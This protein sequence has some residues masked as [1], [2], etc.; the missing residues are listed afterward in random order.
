MGWM[1]DQPAPTGA[2]G[3]PHQSVDSQ[4][5]DQI[6]TAT[7]TG[8]RP[9]PFSVSRYPKRRRISAVATLLDDSCSFKPLQAVSQDVRRDA[10]FAGQ[11]LLVGAA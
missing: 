2:I 3:A 4:R 9:K 6:T 8:A 7:R 1:V 5:A 10:L 11:E